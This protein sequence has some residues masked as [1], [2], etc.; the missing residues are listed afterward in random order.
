MSDKNLNAEVLVEAHIHDKYK[1]SYRTYNRTYSINGSAKHILKLPIDGGGNEYVTVK[2]KQSK[3]SARNLPLYESY[4]IGAVV[5]FIFV[6][7]VL[8]NI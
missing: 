7:V 2:I 5:A 1:G 4:V 3:Q 8:R 6:A